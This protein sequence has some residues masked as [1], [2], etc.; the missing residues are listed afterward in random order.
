MS[1]FKFKKFTK[2]NFVFSCAFIFCSLNKFSLFQIECGYIFRSQKNALPINSLTVCGSVDTDEQRNW[3]QYKFHHISIV[4]LEVIVFRA[5]CRAEVGVVGRLFSTVQRSQTV[6][7]QCT[8][9]KGLHFI[10]QALC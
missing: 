1:K 10:L 4:Y 3:T 7:H 8:E 9:I 2:V 5:F 6:L